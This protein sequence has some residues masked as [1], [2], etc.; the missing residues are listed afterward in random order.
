MAEFVQQQHTH[1]ETSFSFSRRAFSFP[2]GY[3]GG[4]SIEAILFGTAQY[5]PSISP[6]GV[7]SPQLCKSLSMAENSAL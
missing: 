6:A 3:S 1:N 7:H 4:I 5:F 2:T